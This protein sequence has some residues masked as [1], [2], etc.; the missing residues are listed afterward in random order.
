MGPNELL[1]GSEAFVSQRHGGVDDVLSIATDDDEPPVRVVTN[2]LR[3]D[4]ARDHV[5][6]IERQSLSVFD[7]RIC[8]E[9]LDI[10]LKVGRKV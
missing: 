1:G 10:G 8:S 5:L 6:E 7:L 2:S 4:L 3:V 9:R